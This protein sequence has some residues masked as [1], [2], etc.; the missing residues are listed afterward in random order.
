[1][2]VDCVIFSLKLEKCE[3]EERRKR[4]AKLKEDLQA[5]LKDN[6]LGARF[7]YKKQTTPA[8]CCKQGKAQPAPKRPPLRPWLKVDEQDDAA[9]EELRRAVNR[10]HLPLGLPDEVRS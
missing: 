8:P 9:V 10:R 7:E 1:M 3:T 6:T 2:V 4:K 5:M